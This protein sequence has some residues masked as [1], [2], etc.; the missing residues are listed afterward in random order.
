M[1]IAR[2]LPG[3]RITVSRH[4]AR[5]WREGEQNGEAQ[6]VGDDPA[7]IGSLNIL[8]QYCAV[9]EALY[10]KCLGQALF[11]SL[12]LGRAIHSRDVEAAM[13]LC[14]ETLLEVDIT[15]F[16]QNICGHLKDLIDEDDLIEDFKMKAGIEVLRQRR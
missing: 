9:V 1:D 2:N 5:R 12:Q 3:G 7:S 16:I 4:C 10:C 15:A 14:K 11:T 8:S 6:T 13:N